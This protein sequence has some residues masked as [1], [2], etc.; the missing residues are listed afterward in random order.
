MGELIELGSVGKVLKT[1]TPFFAV[2]NIDHSIHQ[3]CERFAIL[4]FPLQDGEGI[5]NAKCVF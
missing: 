4:E 3:L 2:L 5:A 1:H